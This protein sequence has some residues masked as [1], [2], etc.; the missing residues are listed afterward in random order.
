MDVHFV[1]LFL[2]R[3][4]RSAVFRQHGRGA[5]TVLIIAAAKPEQSCGRIARGEE[6]GA[7]ARRR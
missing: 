5:T 7:R 6:E 1:C 4:F 2:L 3:V